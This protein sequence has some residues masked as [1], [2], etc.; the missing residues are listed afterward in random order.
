MKNYLA[1]IAVGLVFGL[2]LGFGG[3]FLHKTVKTK[4]VVVTKT[5]K[6]TNGEDTVKLV[7]SFGTPAQ[8]TPNAQQITIPKGCAIFEGKIDPTNNSPK[9]IAIVC[10]FAT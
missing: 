3:S 10:A 8:I 4:K 7:K 1:L 6:I 2:V 5:I 9:W